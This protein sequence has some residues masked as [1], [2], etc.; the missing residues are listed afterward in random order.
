MLAASPGC[1][2]DI[3]ATGRQAQEAIEALSALVAA[4]FDER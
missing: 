3:R 1:E 4:G 2:V